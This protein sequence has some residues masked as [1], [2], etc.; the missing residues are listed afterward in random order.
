MLTH[1][2]AGKPFGCPQCS[3]SFTREDS[4]QNHL[5]LHVG[6]EISTDVKVERPPVSSVPESTAAEIEAALVDEAAQLSSRYRYK[7][8]ESCFHI[9]AFK[10]IL[11]ST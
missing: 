6:C 1:T 9:R 10:Y 5:K 7:I 2:Q 3:K 11:S 8:L 4:M